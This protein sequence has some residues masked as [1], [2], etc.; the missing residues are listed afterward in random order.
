MKSK[1]LTQLA[2]LI[3][4][5]ILLG[6]IPNIGIIQIGVI[7]LT[8]LH[9]PVIIAGYLMGVKGGLVVGLCFGLTSLYVASTRAF[10]PVDLLFVNPLISVLPRTIFGI[11]SG[12][13]CNKFLKKDNV[14]Y[15]G[16]TGFVSTLIHSL[17]VYIAL[18]IWGQKT[19]NIDLGVT[20]FFKYI[21]GAISINSLIEAVVAG[22]LC[23]MIMKGLKHIRKRV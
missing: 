1:E 6:I 18:Y 3:A 12:Y 19:L 15:Y 9:I 7:S 17:L 22:A 13:L 16:V 20:S 4:I 2:M 8:I 5:T 23:I 11:I 14:V 21:V 10:S